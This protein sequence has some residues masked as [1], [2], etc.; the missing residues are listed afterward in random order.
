MSAAYAENKLLM[1]NLAVKVTSKAQP[2]TQA[3]P[4]VIAFQFDHSKIVAALINEQGRP[5]E[6]RELATP[7]R[8]T[9]AAAVEV[10]KQIV[11][12]AVS[13]SRAGAPINAIGFSV[14]G[15]VDPATGRV[16]IP[17][18]KGWTR[19]ALRQMIEEELKGAGIDVRVPPDEKRA[20]AKYGDSASPAMVINS[21]AAAMAA[22]EAWVG[23]ARGKNNVVYLSIDQDVE[24]GIIIDRRVAPGA[25][26]MAGAAG[27][28]ALGENFKREFESRGC[29]TVEVAG[30]A[31]K[32]R[33]IEGWGGASN[34]MIG[35]LIKDDLSH[36]D[37]AAIVRAARGGDALALNS[38][39]ETC[40]WIG[41]GVANLV[42]ILNP[43]AIVIG[44]HLGLT[45]KPY[46]DQIR[47][48]AVRWAMPASARQCRIANATLG[49]KAALIGA[50]RLAFDNK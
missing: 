22:G 46:L 35:N 41:R 13:Q 31:L 28:F 42:S 30:G 24:A 36:L 18:L 12:L 7:R 49:D 40:R 21:R 16:S 19:V 17:G 26:G 3:Q 44:G 29:L 34:S 6:E 47:E 50:A 10:A 14:A 20:R 32:R 4:L 11:A 1:E 25:C 15:L 37:D 5:V 2:R 33:I 23:A 45:L 8:T 39:N 27:W 38:V 48:E 43:D 9:R